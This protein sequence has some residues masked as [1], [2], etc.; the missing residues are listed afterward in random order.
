MRGV[1]VSWAT[2]VRMPIW[3]WKYGAVRMP[4]FQNIVNVS[5]EITP[6]M[7][8]IA[9]RWPMAVPTW[10]TPLTTPGWMSG[11]T[12][13]VNGGIK[14]RAQSGAVWWWFTTICGYHSLKMTSVTASCLRHGV[15]EP[16][17]IVVVAHVRM[18]EPRRI[19]GLERG[20]EDAVVPALD[21]VEAVGVHH[22]HEEE[23]HVLPDLLH[24]GAF[25]RDHAVGESRH[26]LTR[27]PLRGVKPGVDPH[28]GRTFLRER[29]S[30][31]RIHPGPGEG[32]ADLAPAV[33]IVQVVGTRDEE[34]LHRPPLHRGADGFHLHAVAGVGQLAIVRRD[35]V[36]IGH[37]VVGPRLE[38]EDLRRRGDL[39][40]G[41]ARDEKGERNR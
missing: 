16:V 35:L 3:L 13:P 22:R 28:D 34:Q 20:V 40:G 7:S 18:V 8:F 31:V 5:F 4:P 41:E 2:S 12:G 33:E 9:N 21:D 6:G 37:L 19:G 1:G 14:M 27:R 32:R 10:L 26:G 30:F 24:L 11:F 15:H 38:A 25:L 36:V 23:H 39:A 29:L 17:A